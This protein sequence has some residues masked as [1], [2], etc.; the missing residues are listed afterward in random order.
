MF[1]NNKVLVLTHQELFTLGIMH[2]DT[3]TLFFGDSMLPQVV[4][5]KLC[6][7]SHCPYKLACVRVVFFIF[8]DWN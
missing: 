8:N 3:Y 7:A 4:M 6:I 5:I 2:R 1:N